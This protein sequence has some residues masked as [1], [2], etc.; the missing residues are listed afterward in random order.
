M[1]SAWDCSS[2]GSS[3]SLGGSLKLE[4]R[5]GTTATALK[6]ADAATTVVVLTGYGSI[7][8]AVMR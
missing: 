7:A 5:D 6:E 1:A 3:R 8:T 2:R 4:S